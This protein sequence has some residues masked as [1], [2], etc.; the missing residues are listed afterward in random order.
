MWCLEG[1][2]KVLPSSAVRLNVPRTL[3]TAG[4]CHLSAKGHPIP[5]F[6]ALLLTWAHW[7]LLRGS[8]L[9]RE[10]VVNW[11]VD[12]ISTGGQG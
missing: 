8:A 2:I 9:C 12:V 1:F 6:S 11:D 5:L 7:A 10:Y 4:G 3:L